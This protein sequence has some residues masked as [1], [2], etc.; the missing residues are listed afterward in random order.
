MIVANN[1]GH[2]VANLHI[3]LGRLRD[4]ILVDKFRALLRV[5]GIT[6]DHDGGIKSLVVIFVLGPVPLGSVPAVTTASMFLG[7]VLEAYQDHPTRI[8]VL[9]D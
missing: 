9:I 7:D 5:L 4:T 8:Q 1:D 3:E 6:K 2:V